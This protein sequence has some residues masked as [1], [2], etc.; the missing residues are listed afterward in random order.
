MPAPVIVEYWVVDVAARRLIV[1]REPREGLYGSIKAYG[2]EE[3]V[4]PL[5]SPQK[6]FR[7]GDV[8]SI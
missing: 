7:V 6:D 8:L 4:T 5:A 1:H 3:S 2:E